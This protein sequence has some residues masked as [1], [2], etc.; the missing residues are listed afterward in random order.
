M[1]A[2][3]AVHNASM[4]AL[5]LLLAGNVYLA[6][7]GRHPLNGLLA[8]DVAA[9]LA[10]ALTAQAVNVGLMMLFF[11]FDRPRRAAHRHAEL[12]ALGSDLRAG[13]R[14]GGG[15]L[16]HRQ[17]GG[18]R[19]VRG[20]DAAVRA[21]LQ[22]HRHA[23][24]S[25]AGRARAAHAPV[26]SPPRAAGRA[27]GRRTR[28]AHPGRDA[29]AVPLRRVVSRAGRSRAPPARHP[30]ARAPSRS[31]CRRDHAPRRRLVRLAGR[32]RRAA[33]RQG[34]AAR[35]AGAGAAGR[36]RRERTGSL[37]AVPLVNDG[38]VLGLLCVQ[39]TQPGIYAARRS[40]PDAAARRAGRGR[41]GRRARVRGPGKLS[42]ASRGARH[43]AHRRTR[44]GERRE[45][46]PDHRCCAS[47]ACGWSASRRRTR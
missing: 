10:M 26:R 31:G 46:T 1:A 14:A 37:L 11:R 17:H 28:R 3:R 47:A 15:A 4:T 42:P 19:I 29:H 2:L 7:G 9:A 43:G 39:H 33:A 35:A 6:S 44:E 36:G 23:A 24:R 30:R 27:P 21:Q 5:M 25:G 18:V 16:Q 34:L 8:S 20:P 32:T 13:R 41:A 12:R 45:G 38:I 40:A 22:Q